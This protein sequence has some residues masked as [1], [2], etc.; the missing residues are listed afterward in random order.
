MAATFEVFSTV[1]SVDIDKA[2]RPVRVNVVTF[3]TVPSGLS[4]EIRVPV[5]GFSAEEVRPLLEAAARE[6]EAVK[7][8]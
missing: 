5:E 8:L 2:G 3:T 6:L 7:A 4:G 1:P